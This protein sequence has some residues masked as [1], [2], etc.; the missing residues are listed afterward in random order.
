MIRAGD[1]PVT[2]PC[3]NAEITT[4]RSLSQWSSLASWGSCS[5]SAQ[6]RDGRNTDMIRDMEVRKTV[7]RLQKWR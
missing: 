1:W 2:M 4:L 5:S 3:D 7:D 6:A